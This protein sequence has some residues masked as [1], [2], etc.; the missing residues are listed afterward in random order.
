MNNSQ[1]KVKGITSYRLL[2]MAS[3]TKEKWISSVTL[4]LLTTV[5]G[6]VGILP[7]AKA[8]ELPELLN[9]EL[10]NEESPF[11]VGLKSLSQRDSELLNSP[12]LK[13]FQQHLES[14]LSTVTTDVDGTES[15]IP[16]AVPK[17]QGIEEAGLSTDLVPVPETPPPLDESPKLEEASTE[18]QPVVANPT[19][20]NAEGLPDTSAETVS[21][22]EA[23]LAEPAPT[24]APNEVRILT[25]QP[26]ATS[27]RSTSLVVQY[28]ADAQIQVNVN[29]EPIDPAITTQQERDEVQN[30]ITQVWY[31]IPLEEGE[32]T[33]TVQAGDGTPSSVQLTVEEKA[34]QIEVAPVGDPR[35]PADGRSTISLQG[36]VTDENG[37]LIT[38]ETVVTLTASA[39]KFVGAD[40]DKDQLGFQVTAR[41]GLFTAQLQSGLEAQKVR[42]RAAVEELEQ[43]IEDVR[44]SLIPN[45]SPFE[46]Y[47]Q[48]EF[49]TNLRPSLVSGV[50]NLR[51][52]A[53][54]TDF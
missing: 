29:Q 33:L 46:A 41:E 47:T 36:R 17:S 19:P 30:I 4:G 49:V 34:V 21:Q 52:G 53:S 27:S 7:T 16:L 54:G 2:V 38:E 31:N 20:D 12:I 1:Q 23:P 50:V 37:Q 3:K 28:N 25:P 24:L 13:S 8:D 11:Q 10:S 35:V 48:I 14:N 32:N 6:M 22:N 42:I 40:E 44:Q 51:I 18:P 5:L 9:S 45:T 43:G 26:G 15:A 39:G